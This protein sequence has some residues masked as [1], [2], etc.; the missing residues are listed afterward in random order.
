MNRNRSNLLNRDPMPPVISEIVFI[1]EH[2]TRLRERLLQ[3]DYPLIPN[4]VFRNET[5]QLELRIGNPLLAH[6]KLMKV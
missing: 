1:L 2:L 3:S 5:I 6:P 4:N